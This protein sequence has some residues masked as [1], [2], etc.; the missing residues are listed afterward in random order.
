[1]NINWQ[2]FRFPLDDERWQSKTVVAALLGLAAIVIWPLYLPLAGFGVRVMRQT[3][4]GE[5][6]SLPEWE[7]WGQLFGDGL[8][9]YVVS[10]VYGLPAWLPMCCA[11]ALWMLAFFPAMAADQTAL[12][13][14][15]GIGGTVAAYGVGFV[16]F[17]I[18]MILGLFFGFL[19]LVAQ[20]RWV[21]SG[22]FNSAFEL[23][24]VWRLARAGLN[25]FLLAFAIWYGGLFLISMLVNILLYT[26][27]LACLVPFAMGIMMVYSN[28]LMGTLFGMAYYHTQ[29][30]LPAVE[31][32]LPA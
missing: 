28:L 8:R 7:D 15:V 18:G 30:D 11:I 32:A 4:K 6:P 13:Q 9:F 19:A 12:P 29:S 5:S 23:G 21:A 26:I 24:E 25:N 14:A 1:M 20:T 2:L 16:L 27:V 22:A 3:I 10:L 17:G 31:K